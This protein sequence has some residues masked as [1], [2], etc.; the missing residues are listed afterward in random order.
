[1]RPIAPTRSLP[2]PG[3]Y[4]RARVRA[5]TVGELYALLAES[6]RLWMLPMIAILGLSAVLLVAVAAVE[7]VAPF[8]YTVF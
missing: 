1:M 3:L 8:V 5:G 4:Q 7:Y 2:P 6:G